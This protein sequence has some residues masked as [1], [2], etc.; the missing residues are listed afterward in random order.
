MRNKPYLV[1]ALLVLAPILGLRSSVSAQTNTS[2]QQPDVA[3][4]VQELANANETERRNIMEQ[5]D[6]IKD[7][8]ILVPPVLA[9]LDS[10]DPQDAWRLFDIL[11][12]FPGSTK[13]EPLIRIARRSDEIPSTIK[14]QLTLIGDPARAPLLHAIAEACA[15]WK[16]VPDTSDPANQSEDVEINKQDLHTNNFMNWAAGTL[17]GTGPAVWKLYCKC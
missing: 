1:S 16:P 12:R 14:P 7:Q 15:T 11:A 6:Q 3:S 10:V 4:L 17:A 8:A 9:A 5:L 13:P 2:N